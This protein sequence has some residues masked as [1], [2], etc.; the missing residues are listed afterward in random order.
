MKMLGLCNLYILVLSNPS[1]TDLTIRVKIFNQQTSAAGIA[2]PTV[3]F[4]KINVHLCNCNTNVGGSDFIFVPHYVSFPAGVMRVAF[5]VTIVED[6]ILEHNE[7][8]SVG[9]DP[10]T[11]PNKII[12]GSSSHTTITIIDDDSE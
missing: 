11:L 4:I 5:N 1:A 7:S 10:L 9:V 6:N 2:I 3:N 8:F 12:I